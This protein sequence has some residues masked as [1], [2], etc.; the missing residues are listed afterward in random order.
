MLGRLLL[1]VHVSESMPCL[2]V[3]PFHILLLRP[4]YCGRLTLAENDRAGASD[5]PAIPWG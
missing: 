1:I 5:V 3:A 2:Y 4:R